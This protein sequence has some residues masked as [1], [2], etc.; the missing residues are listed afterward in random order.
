MLQQQ[1]KP[2]S[3]F[4]KPE[5]HSGDPAI[6]P[7][8]KLKRNGTTI[9]ELP[10]DGPQVL[11]GRADDNDLSIPTQYVSQHHILLLRQDGHTI[12]IDLH[13][14]NGTFVNAER[15]SKYVLADHDVITVDRRSMFVNYRIE[16]SEPSSI[17]DSA[18]DYDGPTDPEI[19]K[20]AAKFESLLSGGDTDVLPDFS[21]DVPTIVGVIDDR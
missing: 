13:S 1:T 2:G 8:L 15:V 14:T 20:I 21:E 11:I 3:T 17:A 7:T 6:V 12:L 5:R 9:Q 4:T 10:L 19:E 18:L 16:Y